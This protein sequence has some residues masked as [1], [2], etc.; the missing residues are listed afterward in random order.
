MLTASQAKLADALF[1][2]GAVLFGRFEIKAH[3]TDPDP[4]KSPIYLNLRT[5]RH[6]VPEKRG[7]LDDEILTMVRYETGLVLDDLGWGFTVFT[8]IPDAGE[9]FADQIE[10]LGI[11]PGARL[12][13]A[14]RKRPDGTRYISHL[15]SGGW[16][17]YLEQLLVLDDVV[18]GAGSKLETI[19]VCEDARINIWHIIVLID[20]GQGGLEKLRGM[21]YDVTAIMRLPDMLAYW[22]DRGRIPFAKMTETLDY[23]EANQFS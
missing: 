23:L 19:H 4:P 17:P 6:P 1:D 12:R 8:G 7:P 10:E 20:R 18:S 14:K 22:A 11:S 5:D 16:L 2:K 3:E 15:E 13:L 21:G 9:P